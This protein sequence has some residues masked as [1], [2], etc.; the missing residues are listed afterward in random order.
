MKTNAIF[1]SLSITKLTNGYAVTDFMNSACLA[2]INTCRSANAVNMRSRTE[3]ISR[4]LV[5]NIVTT[6]ICCCAF[7]KPVVWSALT[8]QTVFISHRNDVKFG[9]R[10]S[11]SIRHFVIWPALITAHYWTLSIS[12]VVTC[13]RRC[14]IIGLPA[15]SFRLLHSNLN[16]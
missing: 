12:S 3:R 4:N 11:T 9:M 14:Q 13:L 16:F 5:N 7:C 8:K 2:F 10:V 1:V 6:S 15:I